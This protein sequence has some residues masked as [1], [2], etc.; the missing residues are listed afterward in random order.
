MTLPGHL[1]TRRRSRFYTVMGVAIC[2]VVFVG[3]SRSYFLRALFTAPPLTPRLHVHGFVLGLW[4]ALFIV[5]ARLIANGQRHIHQ[6]L[7][8]AGVALGVIAVLTTYAAA[9]ETAAHASSRGM[10]A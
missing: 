3:F 6:M 7:G 4:L 2:A 9:F 8:V 10:A 5:Q 1:A